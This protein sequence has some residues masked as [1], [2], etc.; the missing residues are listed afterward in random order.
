MKNFVDEVIDKNH[1]VITF[2]SKYIFLIKRRV[3]NI[4][5]IIKIKTIVLK[6]PL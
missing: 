2:I 6:K 1:E 5:D 3:A 4:A